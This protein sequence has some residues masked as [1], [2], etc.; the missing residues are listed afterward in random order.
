MKVFKKATQYAKSM[1]WFS[2]GAL[3]I[4]LLALGLMIGVLLPESCTKT[5]AITAGAVFVITCVPLVWKFVKLW[6]E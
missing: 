3:K 6:K 5:V 4:C 2:I 1:N